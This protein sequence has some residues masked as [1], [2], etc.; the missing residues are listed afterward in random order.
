MW[1]VERREDVGGRERGKNGIVGG[2]AGRQSV[3][4]A[5]KWTRG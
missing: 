4:G 2:A 3:E 5:G 1:G